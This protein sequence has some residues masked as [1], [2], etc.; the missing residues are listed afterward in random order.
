[1][2]MQEL[3]LKEQDEHLDDITNIA[4]QLKGYALNINDQLA[5]QDGYFF[6]FLFIR[7]NYLCYNNED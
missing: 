3:A 7:I 6:S 2:N 4:Y 5:H 1:M